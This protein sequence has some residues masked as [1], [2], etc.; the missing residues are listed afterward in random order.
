L[1]TAGI[2]IGGGA[3]AGKYN[4]TFRKMESIGLEPVTIEKKKK[5]EFDFSL[6]TKN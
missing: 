2:D 1:T 3:V 4:V 6:S 5:N